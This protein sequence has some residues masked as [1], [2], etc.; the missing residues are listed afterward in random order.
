MAERVPG[1]GTIAIAALGAGL[2]V[3]LTAGTTA[4]ATQ[5][6]TECTTIT[7]SGA[8]ELSGNV[9][10]PGDDPCIRI[11]ASDV[12]LD[13]NG[14]TVTT[15]ATGNATGTGVLVEPAADGDPVENVTVRNLSVSNWGTG[16]AYR[17]VTA[18]TIST[19]T[20]T[21]NT[22][23]FVLTESARIAVRDVVAVDNENGLLTRDVTD[24]TFRNVT[25]RN[26]DEDGLYTSNDFDGNRLVNTTAQENGDEGL[27]V[28]PAWNSVFVNTTV[29]ANG[30]DGIAMLDTG[31]VEM[32]G[33]TASDNDGA[34]LRLTAVAG[35]RFENV[36]AR[37]NT[38]AIY[39]AVESRNVTVQGLAIGPDGT[40]SLTAGSATIRDVPSHP[41]LPDGTELVGPAVN[42]SQA[43]DGPSRP[44]VTVTMTERIERTPALLQYENGSWRELQDVQFDSGEGSLTATVG[45][46]IVAPLAPTTEQDAASN[47]TA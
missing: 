14:A 3:G 27:R 33:L 8:Y 30:G 10:A 41:A 42:V 2:L 6:V 22:N 17:D 20:A 18:S 46:G 31:R 44:V 38:G 43:E 9:S 5:T 35:T 15:N 19:V 25:A 28:G 4:A 11:E 40:L 1:P 12:T 29:R 13:G 23:G 21:G 26:N 32:T 39:T 47:G 24:S 37:N 7:E 36:T 34:G 45:N 16:V